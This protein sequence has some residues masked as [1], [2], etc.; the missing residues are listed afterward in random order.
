MKKVFKLLVVLACF[1]GFFSPLLAINTLKFKFN[2]P[3]ELIGTYT[4]KELLSCQD[5]LSGVY[6]YAKDE[7]ILHTNAPLSPDSV[8]TCSSQSV[9]TP[10]FSVDIKFL[11]PNV[12]SLKF[13][14]SVDKEALKSALGV[15]GD[16][17]ALE[18]WLEGFGD[19]WRLQAKS[20]IQKV[21]VN[22]GLKGSFGKA[23]AQ[24]EASRVK[25]RQDPSLIS[26]DE[27]VLSPVALSLGR[28]GFRIYSDGYERPAG[29]FMALKGCEGCE[30]AGAGSGY[31]SE[32]DNAPVNGLWYYF[33]YE[34]V[35][36][37]PE[38]KY[39][40]T[41]KPGLSKGNEI[42]RQKREFELVMPSRL[43]Y[44]A[45]SDKLAYTPNASSIAIKGVNVDKA[46]V[47]IEKITDD[48]LRYFLNFS[49][50]VAM[51]SREIINTTIAINEPKNS[52]FER[53]IDLQD[54][55][56]GD[57]IYRLSMYY[58]NAKGLK[59]KISKNIILSDIAINAKV[60]NSSIFVYANSL[61]SLKPSSGVIS[62]YGKNNTLLA[63]GELREG[64]FKAS[65]KMS[66]ASAIYI[67]DGKNIGLLKLNSPLQSASKDTKPL[68]AMI[69][70]ASELLR[71]NDEINLIAVLR[72]N[73]LKALAN[74][75]VRLRFIAPDGKRSQELALKTDEFGSF[76]FKSKLLSN[77]SGTHLVQLVFEDKIVASKQVIVQSFVPQRIKSQIS[78][79][80]PAYLSEELLKA[81]VES[82]YLFGTPASGLNGSMSLFISPDNAKISG[83]EDFSFKSLE[84]SF[85]DSLN[86]SFMLDDLGSA[87]VLFA[88]PRLA[89]MPQIMR[90]GLRFDAFEGGK[91]TSANTT[92]KMYLAPYI[93]GV[94]APSFAKANSDVSIKAVVLN[95]ADLKPANI[96]ENELNI[97]IYSKEYTLIELD[98]WLRYGFKQRLEASL[99]YSKN[100]SY[101]FK[102]AGFYIIR[103]QMGLAVAEQE[104]FIGGENVIMLSPSVAKA[105]IKL[106]KK[107]YKANELIH[108]NAS[109]P[110][111]KGQAL[112]ALLGDGVLDYKLVE[113]KNSSLSTTLKTPNDFKGGY[114]S[115]SMIRKVDGSKM[116]LRSFASQ[117]VELQRSAKLKPQI[118]LPSI[119]KSGQKVKISLSG[120]SGSKMVLF[121][122]DEGVLLQ[123]DQP[124]LGTSAL[125]PLNLPYVS[126]YDI[127]DMVSNYTSN[128]KE[129]KFGS[130]AV[131]LSAPMA[132]KRFS[133]DVPSL[134]KDVF[135]R[136]FEA[137]VDDKGSAE[138][139]LDLPKGLNS[140]LRL[141]LL[142]LSKDDVASLNKELVVQDELVIKA[143]K[144]S[145]LYEGDELSL[146][147]VLANTS[148]K[149]LK[150]S[151][152]FETSSNL[153]IKDAPAQIEVPANKSVSLSLNLSAIK[154]GEA[155]ISLVARANGDI[156]Q[157]QKSLS[158]LPKTQT[159]QS[160]K[161]FKLDTNESL[162]LALDDADLYFSQSPASA[163]LGTLNELRRSSYDTS[164]AMLSARLLAVMTLSAS[165]KKRASEL[166]L[167]ASA[168]ASELI[169]R[170][171]SKGSFFKF[172]NSQ[173]VD[174]RASIYASWALLTSHKWLNAEQESAI[175]RHL[176][177][178]K[179]DKAEAMLSA[180]LLCKISKLEPMRLNYI[181]DNALYDSKKFSS[182]L[183][184]AILQKAG[185]NQEASAIKLADLEAM[186]ADDRV[187]SL[188]AG[189][190]TKEL[191]EAQKDM[192]MLASN[193]A[194]EPFLR[195]L[196]ASGAYEIYPEVGRIKFILNDKEYEGDLQTK[197]DTKASIK[198]LS[199]L[200]LNAF[201]Y[202]QKLLAPW[203]K[204]SGDFWIYREF[205]DSE[206]KPV[207]LNSLSLNSV[208]YSKISLHAPEGFNGSV[209]VSEPVPSCLEV[210][211]E[212]V[213]GKPGLS[214][215]KGVLSRQDSPNAL[216]VF[217][218]K[219]ASY[220]TAFRVVLRGKCVISA[221]QAVAG[222]ASTYDLNELE[223]VVK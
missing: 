75:P 39:T 12:V 101:K 173:E 14:D 57:G 170:L 35:G 25:P 76:K 78:L 148:S 208:I 195:A 77:Q 67:K 53:R 118:K 149:A 143:P 81:R 124:A 187:L 96:N 109:A 84:Q 37:K 212:R 192:L 115:V 138:F 9:K 10:K 126:E 202:S 100:L 38:Q 47:I 177:S 120:Q 211:N 43:G 64:I 60:S 66:N 164:T 158:I 105:S 112:V 34:I 79:D 214:L 174:E 87:L 31:T 160:Q 19:S 153:D 151:L 113:F 104:I 1:G 30:I 207:N 191:S 141:S 188:Y 3:Q 203:H 190:S 210:I 204:N 156:F 90:L 181:Y 131:A 86:K 216:R 4:A 185:F 125:M 219:E 123:A 142:N 135:C 11:S 136:V 22:E 215:D 33:D 106:D 147:Y 56:L 107:A 171:N 162:E 168:I 222:N 116:V 166:E 15:Y 145:Y 179:L 169:T 23:L 108:I 80:K 178:A 163:V 59:Q 99:K 7:L 196:G 134:D 129:L 2:S 20:P 26:W 44:L 194:S 54:M 50:N 119:A 70:L 24:S 5:G 127:Y 72:D 201:I 213:F 157:N 71:P 114:V 13:N 122:V 97:Q 176:N 102:K 93:V 45:F 48:N 198:A 42:L 17:E 6:E 206:L 63:R 65:G 165:D 51:L 186:S 28:L 29:E 140:T 161:S 82:S 94:Q 117:S 183:M 137:I 182:W 221:V 92:A 144:A 46:Q 146:P 172:A 110:A 16:D 130:G 111:S 49:N 85:Q 150:L 217:T 184:W 189:L 27:P 159:S 21:V 32:L 152:E 74:L 133:Q 155:K 40:L 95:W 41:L 89:Q 8:Y 73:S 83:Y 139:V 55:G 69:Y 121:V 18:F 91:T 209:F 132:L 193:A 205:V 88:L 154:A 128:A 167:E 200:Y 218:D 220:T 62:I 180:F 197:I 58:E 199:P 68:R 36:A 175:L 61:S 103:A 223:M 98:D 52:E